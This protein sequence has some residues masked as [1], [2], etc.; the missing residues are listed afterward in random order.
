MDIKTATRK[1]NYA[2]K[3]V[4]KEPFKGK[5]KIDDEIRQGDVIVK[6]I[7]EL[8]NK[9]ELAATPDEKF[10]LPNVDPNAEP[11]SHVLLG[12]EVFALNN[13]DFEFKVRD[14]QEAVMIHNDSA[15]PD[16][17]HRTYHFH[18]GCYGVSFQ[19]DLL[20]QRRVVD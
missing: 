16:D 19:T 6:R 3:N 10:A 8:T 13:G 12:A 4:N 9:G 20:T 14:G 11:T 1:L 15:H 2:C 18:E 5:F 7:S 17:S